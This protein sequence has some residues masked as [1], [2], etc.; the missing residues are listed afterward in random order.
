MRRME[1]LLNFCLLF[2]LLL[3]VVGFGGFDLY[4]CRVKIAALS[5]SMTQD[6]DAPFAAPEVVFNLLGQALF[7]ERCFNLQNAILVLCGEPLCIGAFWQSYGRPPNA[8][9]WTQTAL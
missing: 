8:M 9:K 7:A 5:A 4:I 6:P 2:R 1:L 3:C